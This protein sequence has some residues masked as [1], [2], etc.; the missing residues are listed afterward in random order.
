MD[1]RMSTS[2]AGISSLV[3]TSLSRRVLTRWQLPAEGAAAGRIQRRRRW[4]DGALS[5]LFRPLRAGRSGVRNHQPLKARHAP[6]IEF[7]VELI[8]HIAAFRHAAIALRAL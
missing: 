3:A 8:A 7:I 2:T 1:N 4:R 5:G 6:M